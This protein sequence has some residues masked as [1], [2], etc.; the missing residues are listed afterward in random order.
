ML[1]VEPD[2]SASEIKAAFRKLA[3]IWH[4]DVSSEPNAEAKFMALSHAYGKPLLHVLHVNA[5][6]WLLRLSIWLGAY[7][8]EYIRNE[9][10][11]MKDERYFELQTYYPMRPPEGH[12]I[13]LEQR[14]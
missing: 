13:Y 8:C 10:K 14:A 1:Q 7:D 5:R 12:T 9:S 6:R 11:K 4:P 2:A 3:L